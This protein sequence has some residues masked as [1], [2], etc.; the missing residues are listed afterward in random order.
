MA[1]G[2]HHASGLIMVAAGKASGC[3]RPQVQH[4]PWILV[5]SSDLVTEN[6][7][8]SSSLLPPNHLEIGNILIYISK[9]RVKIVTSVKS[10]D[11][12]A[13]L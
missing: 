2:F 8:S 6:P 1:H 3:I 9:F 4:K 5:G 12:F 13:A 10:S 11:Q 7:A